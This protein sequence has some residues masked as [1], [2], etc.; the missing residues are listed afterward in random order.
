MGKGRK[1]ERIRLRYVLA[2]LA[3]GIITIAALCTAGFLILRAL[4]KNS[5]YS[6]ADSGEMV[7]SLT[8]MA[9]ELEETGEKPP[10]GRGEQPEQSGQGDVVRYNGVLYRYNSDILTFLFM[11]ID[12]LE[13]VG[14]E[15]DSRFGGQSDAIFLLVVDPHQKKLSVIGIPR[16]TMAEIDIYSEEGLYMG[17]RVAQITLQHS[18]GDGAEISCERSTEAVSRLFYNLPIHGYCAVNM[19]AVPLIN[20]AVGGIDLTVLDTME[21]GG[22]LIEEGTQL[23]LEGMEAY[24]YLHDRDPDVFNSAGRRLQRQKQYLTA[25]SSK[26]IEAVK[27]DITFPVT[28]YNTLSKYMVTDI[29]IDEVSYLATQVMGCTFSEEDMF[30]LPGATIK[31]EKY[32]EFHA[33]E[34]GLYELILKVFYEEV[35]ENP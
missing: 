27:K 17:S 15:T 28:L 21:Y 19:G 8:R 24:Y 1:S 11:G 25:Y 5:L 9:E 35:E 26:A 2:Y 31:G 34:K 14:A 3:L 32:E 30:I 13:E 7:K 29:S 18:Y 33:D 10:E 20:D 22:I 23:H 16:D 6:R 12:R 4:G